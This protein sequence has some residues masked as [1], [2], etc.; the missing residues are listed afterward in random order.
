[1]R[2]TAGESGGIPP[3]AALGHLLVDALLGT[4]KPGYVAATAGHGQ[5]RSRAETPTPAASLPNFC[6]TSVR[7]LDAG[8]CEA[9]A[10]GHLPPGCPD[11]PCGIEAIGRSRGVAILQ[12]TICIVA[13][14][15]SL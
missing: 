12:C 8:Y 6:A 3:A 15:Q 9:R 13:S 10:A 1:M 14:Q 5:D 7:L 2:S 11:N 4:G